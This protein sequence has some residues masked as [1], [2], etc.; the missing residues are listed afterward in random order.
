MPASHGADLRLMEKQD[1]SDQPQTGFDMPSRL[2]SPPSTPL[3]GLIP[4]RRHFRRWTRDYRLILV[5]FVVLGGIFHTQL[6][7]LDTTK[8]W[9]ALSNLPSSLSP[10]TSRIAHTSPPLF[11]A[12]PDD[13]EPYHPAP[14]LVSRPNSSEVA[15][16]S[17]YH[18]HPYPGIAYHLSSAVHPSKN[19]VYETNYVVGSKWN[20]EQIDN[21]DWM[22]IGVQF[23]LPYGM[24]HLSF[25]CDYARAGS[26]KYETLVARTVLQGRREYIHV[27]CPLPS[28]VH[29]DTT[30]PETQLVK[31]LNQ[32][33]RDKMRMQAWLEIDPN[34]KETDP[35]QDWRKGPVSPEATTR[36]NETTGLTHVLIA[37]Q[38]LSGNDWTNSGPG[39]RL[40]ICLSPIRLYPKDPKD[41]N[42]KLISQLKDF[43]EWRVWSQFVGVEVVHWSSRHPNFI[44]WVEK[45]NQL[46]G[47][48]DDFLAAP[49]AS[50]SFITHRRDYGD[51]V[52][53]LADCL[54]RHGVTDKY[55]AMIDFDEYMLARDDPTPYSAMRRLQGLKNDTGTFSI[56]HTYYGGD[57][58][59]PT[60][61]YAPPRVPALPKFP[62]NAYK[63][64]DTLEK[65]DGYRR[66][67]SIYLTSAVKSIWVH[68]QTE[69][70]DD[71]WRKDDYPGIPPDKG[72]YPSQLELMHDRN[73]KPVKLVIEKE[74]DS[75]QP[76][77]WQDMWRMMAEVLARPELEQLWDLALVEQE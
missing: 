14:I 38:E 18:D 61:E 21:F 10:S 22:R 23:L 41:D 11:P 4:R 15:F 35:W 45:L 68:A 75:D 56:D 25:T 24:A 19:I 43:V 36:V 63:G 52:L 60:D 39:N 58:I 8:S 76:R 54:L 32:F 51:Q 3:A 1:P 31:A 66:Q 5:T 26:N 6:F 28:W 50:E 53:Y 62:R 40:G 74:V 44:R 48:H 46:L 16:T 17:H 64:W 42:A 9:D 2:S 69:M 65:P 29:L 73:P 27:E 67:K 55:H 34:S 72:D 59:P 20:F 12:V 33:K 49:A 70:G 77:K 7:G 57:P 30:M 13:I 71:F 47:L 37:T